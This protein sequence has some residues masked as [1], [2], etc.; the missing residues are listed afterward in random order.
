MRLKRKVRRSTRQYLIVVLICLVVLGFAA[1]LATLVISNSI[2]D[3][4][5]AQL[6][7]YS[8]EMD[9]NKQTVFVAT[10]DIKAGALINE[11]NTDRRIEYSSQPLETFITSSDMGKM[12]L[13]DIPRGSHLLT[14]MV[15]EYKVSTRLR[16][17]EYS[18]IHLGTNINKEDTV[19][20]RINFPNGED[21]LIV[22]KKQLKGVSHDL[23][24]C[25]MWLDEDELLRM[26]AAIVDAYEYD[27]TKI[28]LA[29]YI[30]PLIQ[31]PSLVTYT[32]SLSV[33]KLIEENPNIVDR[34]SQEI[35]K[36]IRK[37]LE[38]RLASS[39]SRDVRE[40]DWNLSSDT[41][42][43]YI[44]YDQDEEEA[45][46]LGRDEELEDA[47]YALD[48]YKRREEMITIE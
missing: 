44:D 28:Y 30:D 4:Y 16:E 47:Y 2:K 22:S 3:R 42:Y 46:E 23:S 13:V 9:E 6:D 17:F 7:Q 10:T 37:G 26:S 40:L 14:N 38:N 45:V 5:Q 12:L 19:D 43:A 31:E 24:L 33:L 18:A 48:E 39:F 20:V 36:E 21:Y 11:E 15:T 1:I 8:K 34:C 27:G 41:A 29:K 35:N 25:L 32:P